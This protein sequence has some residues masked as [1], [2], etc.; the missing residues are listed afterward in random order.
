VAAVEP[1]FRANAFVRL[2]DAGLLRVT[3]SSIRYPAR[4]KA[5]ASTLATLP[6]PTI[7][8][9]GFLAMRACREYQAGVFGVRSFIVLRMKK[10]RKASVIS[11]KTVYKGR[12]FDV[13]LDRVREPSG[14]LVKREIVRHRGSVVILAVTGRKIPKVL[15]ERQ[16]RY[17][18]QAELWELPAGKI[19]PGESPLTSAKRELLEE[20]GYK[21]R[22]WKKFLEFYVSPGFLDEMMFIYLATGLTLGVADPEEDEFIESH[23]ISLPAAIKMIA[24]GEI[25]D[26]KTACSV[27]WLKENL[28]SLKFH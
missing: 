16:Y 18:A 15:L 10:T 22:H 26:A 25:I 1:D 2:I 20:T 4:R 23:W 3:I 27:L 12:I 24:R 19:D 6:A 8:M 9:V 7:V 28:T 21:A 17:A 14:V 11:S 5:G 13:V